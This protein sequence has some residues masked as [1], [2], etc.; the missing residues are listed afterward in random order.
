MKIKFNL[1][2][3]LVTEFAIQARVKRMPQ[4]ENKKNYAVHKTAIM[5]HDPREA[6][7]N[8]IDAQPC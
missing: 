1:P 4:M 7:N 5:H 2:G 8:Q 6:T 3:M